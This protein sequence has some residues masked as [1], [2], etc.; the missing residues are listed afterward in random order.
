MSTDRY[1]IREANIQD[2]EGI[3]AVHVK[4][5][6][7]SYAGIMDSKFLEN[8]SYEQRLRLRREMLQSPHF[9]QLMVLYKDQIVGFAVTGLMQAELKN[10]PAK[11]KKQSDQVGEIYGIYLLQEHQGQG[12]GRELFTKCRQWFHE[13]H[14][15]TFV[16]W[17]LKDNTSA[18]NFYAKHDG[19][20]VDE[21]ISAIG[22]EE[23]L[24]YCYQF[25]ISD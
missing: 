6:Q 22:D 19:Q 7:T 25:V 13:Q 20:I 11:P 2:A 12:I 15:A 18:R 1:V 3:A 9:F 4:S 23:F 14:I 21:K 24:E 16:L 8:I 5:W 10:R 17:V